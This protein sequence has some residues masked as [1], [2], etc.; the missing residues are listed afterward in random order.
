MDDHMKTRFDQ[1]SSMKN[2]PLGWEPINSVTDSGHVRVG[3]TS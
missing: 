1:V 2:A 3:K